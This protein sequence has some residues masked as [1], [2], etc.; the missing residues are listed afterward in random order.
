MD[1]LIERRDVLLGL[2]GN[3]ECLTRIFLALNQPTGGFKKK[4]ASLL[5]NLKF[6]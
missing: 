1:S 4:P 5:I 6:D 2:V 3:I